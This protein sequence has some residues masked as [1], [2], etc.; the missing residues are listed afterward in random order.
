MKFCAILESVI[1]RGANL[2]EKINHNL[3]TYEFFWIFINPWIEFSNGGK[4]F[5]INYEKVRGGIRK[6]FRSMGK[7][8][9]L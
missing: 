1:A 2:I 6:T 9:V 5:L 4:V 7:L 3:S 8:L